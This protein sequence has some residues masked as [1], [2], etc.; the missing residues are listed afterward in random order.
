M[1]LE[2]SS[3]ENE[4]LSDIL[5]AYRSNLRAEIHQ[6]G[7]GHHQGLAEEEELLGRILN[8]LQHPTEKTA[9]ASP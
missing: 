9:D 3:E 1:F 6:S 4:L 5:T 2:L 7:A 8:R